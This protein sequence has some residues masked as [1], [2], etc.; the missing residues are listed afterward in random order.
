MSKWFGINAFVN[1]RGWDSN[2]R[3]FCGPPASRRV[4]RFF[5]DYGLAVLQIFLF[6][7]NIILTISLPFS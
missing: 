4:D 7:I 5:G 3:R 2:N 6:T 1:R